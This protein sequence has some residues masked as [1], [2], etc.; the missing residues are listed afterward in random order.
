MVFLFIHLAKAVHT[1]EHTAKAFSV[2]QTVQKSSDCPICDYHITKDADCQTILFSPGS[3]ILSICYDCV[4]Y[5]SRIT[6][7]VGL[8]YSDR[9]PPVLA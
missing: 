3:D 4:A 1:H 5:K 2:E 9:G 6:T 8:S 7:S